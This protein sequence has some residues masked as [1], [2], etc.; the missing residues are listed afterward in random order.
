MGQ[1]VETD[2]TEQNIKNLHV[3][4]KPDNPGNARRKTMLRKSKRIIL[5]LLV[6]LVL[7]ASTYAFA[8]ANTIA[9]SAVGYKAQTI[10]GYVITDIVY[11]LNVTDPAKL[12][13]IIFSIAPTTAGDPKPVVVLIST[14]AAGSENYATSACVVTLV[15]SPYLVTC[16][17]VPTITVASVVQLDIIASSSANPAP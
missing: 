10:T 1:V 6:I 3:S 9:L 14:T 11:D 16:T 12:D 7:T 17:F 4:A 13:K 5:S 15:A 2:C 8:A